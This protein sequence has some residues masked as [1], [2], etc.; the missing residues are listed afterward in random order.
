MRTGEAAGPAVSFDGGAP[1]I[2]VA[3]GGTVA[4]WEPDGSAKP[5][6]EP[7]VGAT[8]ILALAAGDANNDG[9][10]DAAATAARRAEMRGNDGRAYLTHALGALGITDFDVK[11]GIVSYG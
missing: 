3:G 6:A 1:N 5:L 4:T 11:N 7:P 8:E 9:A 2:L 10:V